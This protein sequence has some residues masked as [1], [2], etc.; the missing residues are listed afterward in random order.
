[1][2]KILVIKHLPT[3]LTFQEK[4]QLLKHFGAENVWETVK[5]PL[6][7]F[8]SFSTKEEAESVLRRLHQLEVAKR[9]LIVEYSYEKESYLH[10]RKSVG[11]S[12]I[13]TH[14]I[15]DFLRVL[16]AWNPS[17]DFYQPPPAHLSYKYSCLDP[18]IAVNIIFS[19]FKHKPF[20]V[21]AVHLMNKMCIDTPFSDNP[22]AITFFRE[23]F[24]E[25][26]FK[27]IIFP[28]HEKLSESESEIESGEEGD[29]T[30]QAT[31]SLVK[32]LHTLKNPLKRKG[33]TPKL[34]A[35]HKP[36]GK[37]KHKQ[38]EVFDVVTPVTEGKRISVVIHKDIQ[39]K[40]LE[41]PE[42]VGKLGILEKKIIPSEQPSETIEEEQ[43]TI[44]R[45]ELL[46]NR[47][48]Y[49]DMKL[50]PVYKNYT[51]GQP[52]MRL[53]LKNLAKTV[54]E[55]DVIRIYRQYIENLSEE[56]QNGFDVRV[57]QE[58]RMKGQGFVTFPCIKIAETALNETNGFILQDKPMVVQFARVA[59]KKT[60]D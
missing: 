17:V 60:I 56:N 45:K 7:V 30:Y 4:E 3:N 34:F 35:P 33:S 37:K 12:S 40:P 20:Y 31:P 57:M 29:R 54:K 49:N 13:T 1:M 39:Q 28:P 16:N 36:Q 38:A 19:M 15:R 43:P 42:V 53:Y 6:V 26:F 50:L 18:K 11:E 47:M 21:Q 24:H 44:T 2:S 23:T 55:Q 58:G 9:R 10:H 52:S 48:S 8:A 14:K 27:D 46:K 41:Q 32:R 22:E 25:L 51:P 59:N 5:K